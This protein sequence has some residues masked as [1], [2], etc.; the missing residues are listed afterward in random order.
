[1]RPDGAP[2][3]VVCL[4][5]SAGGLR[6]LVALLRR[7]PADFPWPILVAQHLQ[8]DRVSQMPEILARATDLAVREAT[9]GE[10]PQAGTVYTCPSSREMGLSMAGQI[11]LREVSPGA[12]QR[13]DHLFATSSYSKPGRTVA[14]VLSGTGSDGAAGS[15]VVKLNEGMVIAESAE[16]AE[17]AEMPEAAH[18]AGSVDARLGAEAMAPVLDAL[19]RGSMAEATAATRAIVH[20]IARAISAPGATDFASYRPGTLR[21]RCERRRAILGLDDLQAYRARIAEDPAERAALVASLL[22]P[23]TEFFRDAPAWRALEGEIVPLLA[24]QAAAG[25]SVR[26]WCAGC[27]TGEEAYTL[28]ILLAESIAE[29]SRVRILATDVDPEAIATA[30]RGVF[31]EARMKGVDGLRRERFFRPEGGRLQAVEALREMLEFRVHDVTRE[32]APGRFDLIVCRNV[33]IYFDEALQDR[34]LA[35]FH[36]ALV[37]PRILFLGRSEA[38]PAGFSPVRGIRGHRIFQAVGP[39]SDAS[40]WTLTGGP[41]AATLAGAAGPHLEGADTLVLVLDEAWDVVDAN[42]RARAVL[43]G[44][45]AGRNLLDLFPRWQG[46]PVHDALKAASQTGRSLK[47]R[48]AA[49]P[50]GPMD[51]TLERLPGSRRGLLL[52]ATPGPLA[53]RAAME[54]S[55]PADLTAT[56]DELQSANEELAATNEELQA[57]NE[58]LASLNEEFQSTNQT[59]A[60]ANVELTT[61]AKSTEGLDALVNEFLQARREA[62]LACDAEQRVTLVNR[63]AGEIFGLDAS[64]LGRPVTSLALGMRGADLSRSLERA[65][66]AQVVETIQHAGKPWRLAIEHIRSPAGD[67]LGWICSWTDASD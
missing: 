32:E 57:T 1:M 33:L 13:I 42:E 5:A 31:R 20:E 9:H 35:T 37:G 59:L 18:A 4:G 7:M 38:D 60:T 3:G 45:P 49:T 47:V 8:P 19:A 56:N 23:V 6:S 46:S 66:F 50:V 63:R 44:P 28:A 58:E 25:G 65:R 24:A 27:A 40:A 34:T 2:S 22:I 54:A 11:I 61:V 26:I 14:V 36:Q 10:T 12:P 30:A 51:L 17:Q 55:L 15:L 41:A 52:I 48:A 62:I 64:A 43:G 29:R 67:V 53:A 21:R 16:S 39:L